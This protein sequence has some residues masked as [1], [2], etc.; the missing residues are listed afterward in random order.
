MKTQDTRL[1]GNM[2]GETN[3]QHTNTGVTFKAQIKKK[4]NLLGSEQTLLYLKCLK[5]HI[6]YHMSAAIQM[7][8]LSRK[9]ICIS[10]ILLVN[11]VSN[12][13]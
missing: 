13:R 6:H 5:Y 9:K 12:K 11:D 2:I 7:G 8:F 10:I 3:V 1:Q 4:K